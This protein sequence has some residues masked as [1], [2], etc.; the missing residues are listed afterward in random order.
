MALTLPRSQAT[1]GTTAIEAGPIRFRL[2]GNLAGSATADTANYCFDGLN[3]FSISK[4]NIMSSKHSEPNHRLRQELVLILFAV[5]LLWSACSVVQA[6]MSPIYWSGSQA[7]IDNDVEGTTDIQLVWE[8]EKTSLGFLIKETIQAQTAYTATFKLG[9]YGGSKYSAKPIELSICYRDESDSWRA[10]V[11]TQI[12]HMVSYGGKPGAYGV[13]NLTLNS[14]KH[15]ELV[16]KRELLLRIKELEGRTQGF[17]GEA[18][19]EA[20][21]IP[22][23]PPNI[24]FFL[25]DDLGWADLSCF[26]S[27]F[28]E[29]P[30]CDRLAAQGMRFTDAYA[31]GPVCSPTRVGLMTGKNP[32][33][34]RST[35]YFGGPTPEKWGKHY[36]TKVLP[37]PVSEFMPLSEFTIAEALQAGGYQTCFAGKW[38]CGEEPYWPQYQGFG[39]NKGGWTRGGP[40][41]GDK[42]FSPY[43]N[44]ML[45]DGPKGEHLP[46]RLANETVKF[47]TENKDDPFFAFLSFYSVHTPIMA[48]PDLEA[49]YE[50]KR[51]RMGLEAEWGT[52][53]SSWPQGEMAVRLTQ[54]NPVYAGMVEAMDQAVGKVLDGLEKLDLVD[55]TI[56]VF[57]SDN[58]GL[59]TSGS[60]WM[61]TSSLPL[62]AGKGW[63]YEGGIRVPAMVRW[64]GVVAAGSQCSEPI[65]S[66]DFYP[67][68]LEV[69]GLSAR[70]TQHLDGMSIAPLLRGERFSRDAIYFHYP[71]YGNQGGFPG[72]IIRQGDWKLIEKFEGGVELYNVRNDLGEQNDLA[73][74]QPER[75]AALQMKLKAWQNQL[76]VTFPTPNPA[77][78]KKDSQ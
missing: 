62:R 49:K 58:G 28:H 45:E 50:K 7:T 51:K 75:A 24:V 21:K 40:Y 54:S 69:A 52:E 47:M 29:S 59:S 56:V 76:D 72:G 43:G 35:E 30:N 78:T 63:L 16:G 71:H 33:R 2:H 61:P 32:V 53:D 37:A 64:P 12:N 66:T 13:Y 20:V 55:N 36:N 27:T 5:S 73:Q 65:V 38:H 25:V 77:Y 3:N 8:D 19:L 17:V 10:T 34:T 60:R 42:Y 1:T 22:S 15:P 23:K 26:G 4:V 14:S 6:E 57:T 46:D 41:G 68:L 48:R 44:P 70:P 39:I 31:A 74:R 67:T 9:Q 18:T 11:S